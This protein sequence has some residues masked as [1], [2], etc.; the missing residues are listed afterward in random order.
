MVAYLWT[1]FAQG[2]EHLARAEEQVSRLVIARE[3]VVTRVLQ[4]PA[5]AESAGPGG[6]PAGE[7]RQSSP[8][9]VVT[10]PPWQDGGD[11]VTASQTVQ[12]STSDTRKIEV[13]GSCRRSEFSGRFFGICELRAA[14]R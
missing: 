4:E 12:P 8:I 5:A 11:A 10:V 2:K 13:N 1:S 3:E 9:G 7:P 14:R 6:E